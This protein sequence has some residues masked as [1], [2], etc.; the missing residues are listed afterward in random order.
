MTVS[1]SARALVTAA[2]GADAVA[3]ALA[4]LTARVHLVKAPPWPV[5]ARLAAPDAQVVT[6]HHDAGARH[7]RAECSCPRGGDCAHAAATA[8]VAL[9]AEQRKSGRRAAEAQERAVSSWLVELGQTSAEVAVAPA[10]A[11]TDVVAYVLDDREGE[12]SLTVLAC[13]R[14]SRGALSAGSVLGSL[15]RGTPAWMPL[16]DVRRVAMIGAITRHQQRLVRVPLDRVHGELLADLAASGA[17]FWKSTRQLPLAYGAPRQAQL[18]WRPCPDTPGSQRLGLAEG[19]ILLPAR[20]PHLLDLARREVAPLELGVPAELALRLASGPPVPEAMRATVMRSLGPLLG[21]PAAAAQRAVLRPR[22]EASIVDGLLRL[23]AIASYDDEQLP[24]AIW[25]AARPLA[26]DL[27]GESRARERL[28]ALTARLEEAG[29]ARSSVRL[30]A[31]AR[32]VAEEIV[33]ILRAEGWSCSLAE[34]FPHQAPIELPDEAFTAHLT[35]AHDNPD[36]FDFGLGVSVGGRSVPLLPLVLEAIRAGQLVLTAGD[37]I[38]SLAAGLNLRLPEGELVHVPAE[39]L[40]RWL[41]PLVELELAGLERGGPP[42]LPRAAVLAA[43]LEPA[44]DLGP[45]R[46][47][48]A[49]LLELAPRHEAASFAGRLRPY[50]RTG[51]AWLHGLHEARLG[52]LLADEMGLGK[53]VQVLAF[54]HDLRPT[55]QRPV[56]VVAPR[57][58]CGNWQREAARFCPELESRLHLGSDR[59]EDHL[60]LAGAP[61]LI[62]SYQTLV[63]DLPLLRAVQWSTVIF[64]EAQALKNPDTQVHRAAGELAAQ[65]RF[66]ITGTPIENHL[67]ELWAQVQVAVPGLL[68]Q[69]RSFDAFFRRPVEKHGK[70][71]PLG[72][73][74]SRLRPFL[75]RRR[76][77]DVELDL[78]PLTEVTCSIELDTPERDLY[79]S[80]RLKLDERVSAALRAQGTPGVSMVILDALLKLRQCCCDPRLVKLPEARRVSG[81][82]K[83]EHLVAMLEELCDS[84]RTALV[85]SQFSEMLELI[86]QACSAAGI[87]TAKLTG[88]SR[89]RDA[90]VASFQAGQVPVLL[91]SLKAGGVGLNLTRADTVIHYEPWWNPAAEAQATARAHRLG[92]DRPVLVYRL[93]ARGTLEEAIMALQGEKRA[94]ADAV[95][96]GGDVTRLAVRD[97]EDLYRRVV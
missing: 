34:D 76:K 11:A 66:C 10:Q 3:V 84:G 79:E 18:E 30:L 60:A 6:V 27:V 44:F 61:L 77:A 22:L 71:A 53:T 47:S 92:Q 57:S 7:L 52:G 59:A 87:A 54:L 88:A 35:P 96:E 89:D 70:S 51:L 56:L 43:G 49:G 31:D 74:R 68:G 63:R 20:E 82:A 50:Q 45:A 69:R 90:V 17:L 62:T 64:D 26:R 36:W 29:E 33:P 9:A 41:R 93:V 2:F 81:S 83:L 1:D 16:A 58:V 24:L 75:L 85:F 40:R 4:G 38:I 19:L 8:L 28:R 46:E 65:S 72:V 23:E 15:E 67:G 42:R 94:L 5:V 91:V 78:P 32:L 25:D 12:L 39:R 37:D 48:L 14:L 86:A 80:L 73:L 95:L 55:G 97:L 21:A 13:V